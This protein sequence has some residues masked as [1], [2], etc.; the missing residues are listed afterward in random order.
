M[1]NIFQRAAASIRNFFARPSAPVSP[2]LGGVGG[3]LQSRRATATGKAGSIAVNII[4]ENTAQYRKDIEDWLSAQAWANNVDYPNRSRLVEL[5]EEVLQDAMLFSQIANR[6]RGTTSAK[7]HLIDKSSKPNDE[8]TRALTSS[9]WFKELIGHVLDAQFFGHSLVEYAP[10]LYDPLRGMLIDRRH[11]EPSLGIVK[12]RTH[13]QD[14]IPYRTVAEYGTS[15]LEFGTYYDLGLLNK[16]V[17]LVLMRKFAKACFSEYNEKFGMPP[18][19]LKTNTDDPVMVNRAMDML[20]DM[21]SAAQ[22]VLDNTEEFQVLD[23]VISDGESYNNFIRILDSDIS[24]L[25]A[26]AIIGQDTKHGGRSKEESSISI[27]DGLIDEDKNGVATAINTTVLP[28]LVAQG[29]VPEGLTFEWVQDEDLDSLFDK[30]IAA[31][32]YYDVE[33]DFITKKFGIPVLPK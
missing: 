3:G 13:D 15:V 32:Q 8:A 30:V 5:Y 22:G 11:V 9:V 29:I 18:L 10:S 17:P 20:R 31:S 25:I 23:A 4:R 33:P 28:A 6:K 2:P 14:G 26:G 21:G 12:Q 19:F 16:A 1:A 24:L 27:L 7:Y